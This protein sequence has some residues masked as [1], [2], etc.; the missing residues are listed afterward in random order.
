MPVPPQ[1][2][3]KQKA[4]GKPSKAA[5]RKALAAAGDPKAIK[6]RAKKAAKGKVAKKAAK[7]GANP[8][9]KG[10]KPY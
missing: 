1:F 7:K 6:T 4:K 8:F 2:A 10:Q 5:V 3:K 9:A